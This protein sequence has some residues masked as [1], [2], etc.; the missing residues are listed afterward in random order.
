VAPGPRDCRMVR[1]PGAG[2]Q[3][4]DTLDGEA[5]VP[6]AVKPT[7]AVAPEAREPLYDALLTVTVWP[8]WL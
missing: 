6:V 1:G 8:D 3:V 4:Q 2:R 5:L 7:V